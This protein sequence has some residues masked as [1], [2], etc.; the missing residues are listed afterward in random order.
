M[1]RKNIKLHIRKPSTSISTKLT[2][3]TGVVAHGLRIPRRYPMADIVNYADLKAEGFFRHATT[4]VSTDLGGS[5]VAGTEGVLGLQL[6]R[7]E[8]LILLVKKGIIGVE[9][10][11]FQGSLQYNIDDLVITIPAG[12]VGDLYEIDLFDFGLFIGGVPNEKGIAIEVSG[13]GVGLCLIAR[14]A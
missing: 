14:M 1:A 11:T 6:P 10:I 4:N 8:K 2:F 9:T 5:D 3:T 7:T 13:T 12:A